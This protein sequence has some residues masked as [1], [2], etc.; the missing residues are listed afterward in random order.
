MNLS[1]QNNKKI[2]T[3]IF[4][5]IS[6]EEALLKQR[7][8]NKGLI[9]GEAQETIIVCEHNS[10]YTCGIHRDQ[11]PVGLEN[12]YFIERGGGITYHGPGQITA[13]FLMDLG[14][15]KMN[16]LNLI[17]FVHNTEIDFLRQHGIEARSELK[18]KTGIWVGNRK[19]SSTGFSIKGGFTMH[20]IGLNINTD[21]NKFRIINPCGF[22]PNVMTSMKEITG[23]TY[24]MEKEKENFLS[25]LLENIRE[26]EI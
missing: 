13:Y 20:G 25:L 3:V 16:I 5:S 2:S 24:V 21:L 7:E 11:V 15:R 4:K 9:N 12:L 17:N 19:I 14:K 6:Y 18:E 8:I 23:E 26:N 1:T 22:D 10:V